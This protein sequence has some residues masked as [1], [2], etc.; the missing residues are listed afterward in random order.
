MHQGR[1]RLGHF[2]FVCL[3]LMGMLFVMCA[4]DEPGLDLG[5][6]MVDGLG[7]MA[8]LNMILSVLSLS[9]SDPFVS[10]IAR[11]LV[12]TVVSCSKLDPRD[13]RRGHTGDPPGML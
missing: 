9:I 3:F 1:S 12:W 4:D 10:D 6:S 13:P 5:K 7:P 2:L 8:G 11:R